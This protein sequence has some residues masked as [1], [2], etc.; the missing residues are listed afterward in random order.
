MAIAKNTVAVDNFR[1]LRHEVTPVS[2]RRGDATYRVV[3]PP[4]SVLK[5]ESFS[6]GALFP[7]GKRDPWIPLFSRVASTLRYWA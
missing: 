7:F 5:P 2:G 4:R 1:K 6:A 3:T